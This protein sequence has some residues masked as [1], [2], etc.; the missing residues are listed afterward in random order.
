[1][2]K[3]KE[4]ANIISGWFNAAVQGDGKYA[5]KHLSQRNTMLLV[6][7]DPDEWLRGK[8]ATAFLSNE[9]TESG[10]HVKVNIGEVEAYKEGTVGW[11]IAHPTITLPNGK[12][13]QPRWSAVFHKERGQWKIVQIH[14][15][16]GVPNG[17][18]FG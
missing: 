14:A 15:S 17:Q 3:S 9:A 6:G 1:M 7:T 5:G 13:V 2:E 16:V 11:G 4:L 12:K 18:A 10:G 8:A